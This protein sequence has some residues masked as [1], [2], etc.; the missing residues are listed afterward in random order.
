M[1]EKLPADNFEWDEI[2]SKFD[3]KIMIKIMIMDIYLKK[4]LNILRNFKNMQ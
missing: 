2:T 4:L 3:A 1:S